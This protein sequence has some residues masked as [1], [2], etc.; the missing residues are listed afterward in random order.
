MDV[1]KGTLTCP[2]VNFASTVLPIFIPMA[3]LVVVGIWGIVYY[4]EL[5]GGDKM[6]LFY[7][8]GIVLVIASSLVF[9][10]QVCERWVDLFPT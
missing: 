4:R 6:R 8:T 10:V 9:A 3:S 2:A 7:S 5:K 1:L